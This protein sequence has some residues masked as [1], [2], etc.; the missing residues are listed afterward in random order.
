M[1]AFFH[2]EDGAVTVDW[3][4]LTA[5]VLLMGVVTSISAFSGIKTATRDLA[6]YIATS[7]ESAGED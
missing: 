4:L 7:V 3:V 6:A 2:S 5:A 1:L